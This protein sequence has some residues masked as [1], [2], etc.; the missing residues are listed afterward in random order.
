MRKN[1]H[2][3]QLHELF[4]VVADLGATHLP[5]EI[6]NL[7]KQKVIPRLSDLTALRLKIDPDGP[8]SDPEM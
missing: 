7:V 4:A 2:R 8:N 1:I 5:E 3:D 6:R